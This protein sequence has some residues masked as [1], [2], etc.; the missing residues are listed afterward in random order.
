MCLY[1]SRHKF[2]LLPLSFSHHIPLSP[3]SVPLPLLLS[4]LSVTLPPSSAS[5]EHDKRCACI[6]KHLM[7][8]HTELP[9]QPFLCQQRETLGRPCFAVVSSPHGLAFHA[10]VRETSRC[11]EKEE[12]E[13]GERREEEEEDE[14]G[15]KRR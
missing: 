12:K 8:N 15:E 2:C 11:K 1:C 13:W 10:V 14:V 7:L 9:V 4:A 6:D 3:V 5:T